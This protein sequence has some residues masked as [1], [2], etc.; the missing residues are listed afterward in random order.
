MLQ[1]PQNLMG[2]EVAEIFPPLSHYLSLIFLYFFKTFF[3]F[4]LVRKT[5][6]FHKI[7]EDQVGRYL[8]ACMKLES[9]DTMPGY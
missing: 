8:R 2:V 5:S 6:Q 4:F 3:F 1:L 9:V 7:Y